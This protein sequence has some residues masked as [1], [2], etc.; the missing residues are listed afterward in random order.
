MI[1]K[2][3]TIFFVV[4]FVTQSL[5]IKQVGQF[6]AGGTMVEELPETGSCKSTGDPIDAKWLFV[7][8]NAGHNFGIHNNTQFSYIHF[9]EI[10]PF[11]LASDVQT[12]PP[13]FLC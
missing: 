1:K 11:R 3:I 13:N 9:S 2:A 10:L 4:L 8:G 5:P 12:P 6:I 7:A